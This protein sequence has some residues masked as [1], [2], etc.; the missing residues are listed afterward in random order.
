[1]FLQPNHQQRQLLSY[2]KTP[3]LWTLGVLMLLQPSR[4]QHL[5]LKVL[6][7]LGQGL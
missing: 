2:M 3:L 5:L 6:L 1:M 4:Q 7:Q